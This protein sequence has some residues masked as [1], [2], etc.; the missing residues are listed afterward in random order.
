M[1]I[2]LARSGFSKGTVNRQEMEMD[3]KES[4]QRK[5]HRCVRGVTWLGTKGGT[6]WYQMEAVDIPHPHRLGIEE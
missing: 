2:Q 4:G 5:G 1:Q 6:F 3:S